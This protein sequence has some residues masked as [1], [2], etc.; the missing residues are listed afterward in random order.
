MSVYTV[1]AA[2][3][4]DLHR[5]LHDLHSTLWIVGPYQGRTLVSVSG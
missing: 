2:V 1:V 3:A 5:G 4:N